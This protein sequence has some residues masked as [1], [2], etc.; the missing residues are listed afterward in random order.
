MGNKR[1][2][3]RPGI[4]YELFTIRWLLF[5]AVA[6]AAFAV[7][8]SA[9][10]YTA[11]NFSSS[12]QQ[13]TLAAF[14]VDNPT[15]T[16]NNLSDFIKS[17][18]SNLATLNISY[19][20]TEPY[21]SNG[22]ATD[23]NYAISIRKFYDNYSQEYSMS[24]LPTNS[25]MLKSSLNSS[26][27]AGTFICEQS[28]LSYSLPNGTAI[29]KGEYICQM[30][31]G[32][33]P[34]DAAYSPFEDSF[35]FPSNTTIGVLSN[36]T[37]INASLSY[38]GDSCTLIRSGFMLEKIYNISTSFQKR[39]IENGTL[40]QCISN[41]YYS[42]LFGKFVG[43]TGLDYPILQNGAIVNYSRSGIYTYYSINATSVNQNVPT[44]EFNSLP[45]PLTRYPTT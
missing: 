4:I 36:I 27:Q 18:T 26:Y 24:A 12:S 19:V 11:P 15:M 45:G 3:A 22:T 20:S 10:H 32:M 21:M 34:D 17:R 7:F 38:A 42:V 23:V 37:V 40:T 13:T 16:L 1:R 39:L 28:P 25:I 35:T 9:T 14:F 31:Q 8:Y 5:A 2:S 41:R 30:R 44:N 29:A 6:I 43:L 33:D